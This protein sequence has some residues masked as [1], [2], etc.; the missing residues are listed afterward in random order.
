MLAGLEDYEP[1]A[2]SCRRFYRTRLM[3]D[4]SRE[5]VADEVV[6]AVQKGRRHVRLPKRAAPG[7]MLSEVP[8]RSA[9]VIL[10]GV[11]HRVK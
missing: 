1:T 5:K 3:V 2:K 10:T 4:V 9:G 8:R 7:P 6:E 11:P